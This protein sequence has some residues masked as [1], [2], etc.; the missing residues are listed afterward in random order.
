MVD[1]LIF[2]LK[3]ALRNLLIHKKRMVLSLLGILFAVMSL[4]AFGN[5]SE[6]L[7]A[8]LEMEISRFGENLIIL[9]SGIFHVA[10]RTS[11]QFSE[12]RTLK[13][14]DIK[15]IKESLVEIEEVVPFFDSSYPLRFGE[16]KV[17]ALIVGAENGVFNLRNVEIFEGRIFTDKEEEDLERV[18]V[19]GFKVYE[20]LFAPFSPIGKYLLIYR[21]PTE[22]IGV[23][24][25]KGS[26]LFGQDQDLVVYMPLKTFMRRYSNVDYVKGAYIKVKEGVPL[27][28]VK[29]KIRS[30]LRSVR[31]MKPEE[32]D[33]F[34]IFTVEDI[35]K[36][37]EE[38]TRLVSILTVISSIISFLI[39]GLG[40]FAI[41]LLS[42]TER[43]VEIGI[44]RAFGSSKKDTIF[45]FL[46]ESTVVSLIGGISG[47]LFGFAATIIVDAIGDFPFKVSVK[48]LI[49][50][51]SV[52]VFVGIIA[53]IYPAMRATTYEPTEVLSS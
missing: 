46:G 14:K 36:T 20:N 25:E 40:I 30:F 6:G 48:N 43:R 50:A 5:I 37:K 27:S 35:L 33:D 51:L 22:I 11:A 12:A 44:R 4:V 18:A 31:K 24:S 34:S 3:I 38:G 2:H 13:M 47:V 28:D 17:T 7:K 8:K 21:V 1:L 19:V 16:K 39:G 52:C 49:L 15:S 53:G 9:R 23:M 41:M 10:G 42:V 26:D 45:Q 29:Q 32:K